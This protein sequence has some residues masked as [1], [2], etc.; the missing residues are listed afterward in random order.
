MRR[1]KHFSEHFF[2]V[3]WCIT[4]HGASWMPIQKTLHASQ[5]GS[6]R[7][8]SQK[9]RFKTKSVKSCIKQFLYGV[10]YINLTTDTLWA[11][12]KHARVGIL[13]PGCRIKRV[14]KKIVADTISFQNFKRS[15]LEKASS[16][17][18]QLHLTGH[19]AEPL[20]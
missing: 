8:H 2:N 20:S 12:R 9:T 6:H 18:R 13:Q 5:P 4:T 1:H 7:F 11:V 16:S 3:I 14:Y 15:K 17:Q 19:T 10:V